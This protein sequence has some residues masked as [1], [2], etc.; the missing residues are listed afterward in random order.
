M[1]RVAFL[2]TG[3]LTLF[4]LAAPR[5]AA[6]LSITSASCAQQ[7]SNV[8]RYDCTV[9][10]D[11][12][13]R[14]VIDLCEGSGCSFDRVSEASVL[15]TTHEITLWNLKPSTTYEWRAR[16][17]DRTVTIPGV[18]HSFTTDDLSDP[19]CDGVDDLDLSSLQVGV[20]TSTTGTSALDNVIFSFGC[21]EPGG[22]DKE[23]IL[24]TDPDGT[25]VWYQDSAEAVGGAGSSINAIETDWELGRIHA[26]MAHQYIVEYD[27]SGELIWLMCR[28]DAHGA[29]ENG[30]VPDTCFDDWVHHD[31][32]LH[33]RE[34][35]ALTAE[36]VSYADV[37]DCDGDPSTTTLDFIQDGVIG[38]EHHGAEILQW[39][40]S[41]AMEPT[42]CGQESYWS[43]EMAGEDWAH[44]NSLWISGDDEW[45]LS[46][47]YIN[48]VLRIIGDPSDSDY[49][50]LDWILSGNAT[51]TTDDWSLGNLLS[52]T[53]DFSWQHHAWWTRYG[54]MFVYDNN[55][56]GPYDS[57]VIEFM[58]EESVMIA[59][60]VAEW[61]L[62]MVCDG[63]GGAHKLQPEDHLLANCSDDSTT[64][65]FVDGTVM[66]FDSTGSVVWEMTVQCDSS[67]SMRRG[68]LY[69]AEPF[70]FTN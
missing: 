14:V 34:I 56:L 8:L 40:L 23:Y 58:M 35:W 68:P 25:I 51:D 12:L 63:Q 7:A 11:S 66:E 5:P 54:S 6:A 29:C 57:R 69:R 9:T 15:E 46:F 22:A 50:T 31:L 32:V 41:E 16:A 44:A 45:T 2:L 20:T 53:P 1:A 21:G 17:D 42:T 28:C 3:I 65:G 19:D 4:A 27:L 38:W 43:H 61:D 55:S 30:E 67:D 70:Q 33:E 36:E 62:G 37:D 10:T 59:S 24:I 48:S 13:A 26:I 47:R 52:T 18:T 39:D 60:A 64:P 49:G